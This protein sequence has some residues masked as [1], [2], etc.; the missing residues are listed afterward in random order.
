M[1]L[2]N[3]LKRLY[4]ITTEWRSF[5]IHPET[6]L[7]GIDLKK[8]F[9][10][11]QLAA[12]LNNLIVRGK[13]LNLTFGNLTHMPNSNLAHQLALIALEENVFDEINTRIMDDYFEHSKDIGNVNV[14]M[15][16]A[17]NHGLDEQKTRHILENN[18]YKDQV[19]KLSKVAIDK[20]ITSTPTF[21]I[22]D[23]YVINGA[24]PLE[25]FIDIIK[26]IGDE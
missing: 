2:I 4:N 24:Q 7:K 19:D 8:R 14:L 18:L 26:Q 3:Q 5:E 21:I 16:I 17:I 25:K 6:P 15:D 9:G 23:R 11:D 12:S 10:N 20:L 13:D 22:N 1:G